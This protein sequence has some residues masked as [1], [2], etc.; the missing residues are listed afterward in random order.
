MN[1]APKIAQL[2]GVLWRIYK[3]QYGPLNPPIRQGEPTKNW[4]RFDV[5]ECATL[6]GGANRL[7]AFLESFAYFTP[8]TDERISA[9]F[10]D[11]AEPISSQWHDNGFLRTGVL[12]KQ[13]RDNR[14]LCAFDAISE[15]LNLIDIAAAETIGYLRNTAHSWYPLKLKRNL[16]IDLSLL[17]GPDRLV[18]TAAANWLARYRFLDGHTADGVTYPSRHGADHSCY[19]F[20]FRMIEYPRLTP[21]QLVATK[22]RTISIEGIDPWDR[23]GRTAARLCGVHYW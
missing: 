7:T 13:W 5:A 23:D 19:A 12:A 4:A 20:W 18:T 8:E 16:E 6:Y 11:E 21:E 14:N 2:S 1:L 15:E 22:F 3:K 9:L 10:D 17:T